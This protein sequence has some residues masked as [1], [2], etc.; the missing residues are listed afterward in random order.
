[1]HEEILPHVIFS[2]GHLAIQMAD[3]LVRSGHEVTMFSPGR[4][5]T[6]ATIITADLSYFERELAGRGD[7]YMELL[8]KHPLTFITLARQVQKL[9]GT[10]NELKQWKEHAAAPKRVELIEE[11]ESLVGSPDPPEAL[12]KRIKQLQD[13]WKTVS[14]GIVI[15]SEA[16]WQRFHQASLAAYQPCRDYF[17]ARAKLAV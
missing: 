3:G 7:S 16:D 2:P 5:K 8:K 1:M 14:K 12:A 6:K 13:D 11:M 9:D 4:V 10:L 15:D 17:E